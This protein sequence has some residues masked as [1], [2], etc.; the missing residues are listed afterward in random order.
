MSFIQE[1]YICKILKEFGMQD[2]K[3]IDTSIVKKDILIY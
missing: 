1:I 3:R 2:S